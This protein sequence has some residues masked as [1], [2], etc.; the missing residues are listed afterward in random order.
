MWE[1]GEYL[2]FPMNMTEQL[3]HNGGRNVHCDARVLVAR[4]EQLPMRGSI[5]DNALR[6]DH[7]VTLLATYH[8]MVRMAGK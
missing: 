3:L 5:P 7:Q 4:M 2:L 1:L 6:L 8:K